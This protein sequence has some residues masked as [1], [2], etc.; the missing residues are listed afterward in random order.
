MHQGE[1]HEMDW[2]VRVGLDPRGGITIKAVT[3]EGDPVKL[4]PAQARRIAGVLSDLADAD[5][6]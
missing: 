2:D 4:S 1:G 6:A 3:A 5:E